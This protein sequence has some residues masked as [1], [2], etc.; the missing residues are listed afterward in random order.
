MSGEFLNGRGRGAD[1]DVQCYKSGWIFLCCTP[2]VI[3]Q[4][5]VESRVMPRYRP[6]VGE[7]AREVARKDSGPTVMVFLQ[8]WEKSPESSLQ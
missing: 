4:E 6:S 2:C 5:R 3:L 7:M 8:W 1:K